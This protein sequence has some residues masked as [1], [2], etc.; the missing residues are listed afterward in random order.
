MGA[1][2]ESCAGSSGVMSGGTVQLTSEPRLRS[3]NPPLPWDLS[4]QISNCYC[5]ATRDGL[6]YIGPTA[7]TR[8]QRIILTGV[9]SAG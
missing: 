3:S 1:K 6:I 7:Q 8:G 9:C 4:L 5:L 2:A